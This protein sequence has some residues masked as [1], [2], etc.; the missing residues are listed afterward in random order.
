[1]HVTSD[2]Q[3]ADDLAALIVDLVD[4][5]EAQRTFVRSLRHHRA[6]HRAY[7]DRIWDEVQAAA[8]AQ[9]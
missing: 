8:A 9:R 6:L 7:L 1:M 5:P 4:T 3:H 2:V